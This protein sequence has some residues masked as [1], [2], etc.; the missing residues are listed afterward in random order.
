[1]EVTSKRV[2][3]E[4]NALLSALPLIV[5]FLCLVFLCR[6]NSLSVEAS[7]LTS[8]LAV[9]FIRY[10]LKFSV[11]RSYRKAYSYYKK[12][13]Y[14]CA[15]KEFEKS[16]EFFSKHAWL[17][18]YRSIFLL[19]ANR[20]SYRE[21]ALLSMAL[22]SAMLGRGAT[23]KQYLEKTLEQF[24]QSETAQAILCIVSSIENRPIEINDLHN[25]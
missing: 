23:A 1:M 17:D 5:V 8:F 7:L 10:I 21:T 9:F 4:Q 20:Q 16:Y 11:A 13:D 18:T 15:L 24:P 25:A 6:F 3:H 2:P 12:G 14:E 22:C 19:A